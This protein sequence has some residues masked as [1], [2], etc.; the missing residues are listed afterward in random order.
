MS[1]EWQ[2][3]LLFLPAKRISNKNLSTLPRS[4][5][6]VKQRNGWCWLNWSEGFSLSFWSKINYYI[7]FS[8][9]FW[10]D[11]CSILKPFFQPTWLENTQVEV[12][13]QQMAKWVPKESISISLGKVIY[14]HIFQS[15]KI[16]REHVNI[17]T[18]KELPKNLCEM[19]KM[20]NFLMFD[21]REKLF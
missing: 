3:H 8:H 7:L 16:F 1:K 5:Q 13:H 14:H 19:Y 15:F 10:L 11:R 18:R 9:I 12:E 20:W 2:Q 17:V 6:V 4:Y 21:Q